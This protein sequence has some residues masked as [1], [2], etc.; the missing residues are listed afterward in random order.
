M[1][2]IAFDNNVKCELAVV[3]QGL[4]DQEK[5]DWSA[6]LTDEETTAYASWIEQITNG[7]EPGRVAIGIN[8]AAQSRDDLDLIGALVGPA[9]AAPPGPGDCFRRTRS[10]IKIF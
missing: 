6:F 9:G 10:P 3:Y 1:P 7:V 5:F 2:Q 4:P 8:H